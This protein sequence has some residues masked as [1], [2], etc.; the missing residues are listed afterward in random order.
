M[1]NGLVS[2]FVPCH[3][4]GEKGVIFFCGNWNH[5]ISGCKTPFNL[6]NNIYKFVV[7]ASSIF[8]RK[9]RQLVQLNVPLDTP[10]NKYILYLHE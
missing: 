1:I 7:L 8:N 3:G 10:V 5:E 2:V 9:V 4:K 6:F